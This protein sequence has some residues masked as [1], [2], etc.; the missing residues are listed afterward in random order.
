MHYLKLIIMLLAIITMGAC[1]NKAE[2]AQMLYHQSEQLIKKDHKWTEAGEMLL[3]SLQLQDEN[4][5]TPLLARTYALLS[6]VY[7]E[8]DRIK[9]AIEYAHREIG[10]AS[11]RER[12]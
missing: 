7:W 12:V 1:S 9:K 8:E 2:K 5:P 4:E 10:R 11:C 3:G 6:K